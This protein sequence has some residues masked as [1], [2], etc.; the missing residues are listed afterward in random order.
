MSVAN[1]LLQ[2]RLILIELMSHKQKT[3]VQLN[4]HNKTVLSLDQCQDV[5]VELD[6]H[7]KGSNLQ[8]S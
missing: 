4:S 2:K 3:K 1:L 5:Q 8:F 6:I 7:L